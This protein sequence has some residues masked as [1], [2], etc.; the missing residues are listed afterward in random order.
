MKLF[1]CDFTYNEWYAFDWE[2][3]KAIKKEDSLECCCLLAC[4]KPYTDFWSLHTW[5]ELNVERSRGRFIYTS[6]FKSPWR[7]A[8]LTSIC[9][10]CLPFIATMDNNRLTV[11]ILATGEKVSKYSVSSIWVLSL[12]ISLDLYLSMELLAMYL[13]LWIH[14]QPIGTSSIVTQHP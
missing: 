6:S 8:L 10:K 5:E 2:Y 4:F 7:E 12:A 13:I 14:L 11:V 1:L 3:T 9:Y